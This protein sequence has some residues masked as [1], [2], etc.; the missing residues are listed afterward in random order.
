MLRS[1]LLAMRRHRHAWIAAVLDR[2]GNCKNL[3]GAAALP[4][5]SGQL[6]QTQ[7]Q[8]A[9]HCLVLGIGVEL[10][11]HVDQV[12]LHRRGGN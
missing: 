10:L 1:W 12:K 3:Q 8:R 11:A 9:Q 2:I 4:E 5:P 7:R 6:E